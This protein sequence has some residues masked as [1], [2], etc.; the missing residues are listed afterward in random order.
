MNILEAED[1][2]K[3]LP[4]Q[5]L[6]Q[7]AQNPPPQIP[8]YLAVSEVQ[9]R[10]DMRQ[11]F[12]S[13]QAAQ[14]Q[15]TV[16]DQILQGGI[17]SAGGPPPGEA[18]PGGP[19][20]MAPPGGA[21]PMGGGQP[22][23][24]AAAGGMMPYSMG[25]GGSV[26]AGQPDP[27]V[28]KQFM[29]RN[30]GTRQGLASNIGLI[31][32]AM[33]G[34]PVGAGIGGNLGTYIGQKISPAPPPLTDMA[35][36][37]ILGGGMRAPERTNEG[38]PPEPPPF[39]DETEGM[40]VGGLVIPELGSSFESSPQS[41]YNSQ[42][43]SP[44]PGLSRDAVLRK[45]KALMA[46]GRQM[47]ALVLLRQAGVNPS[48]LGMATGGMTPGGIVYMQ[49]GRTVPSE[50]DIRRILEKSPYQRTAE[51]NELLRA[52]GI[53]LSRRTIPREGL[54]LPGTEFIK[55][56]VDP[57]GLTGFTGQIYTPPA[58]PPAA[59]AAAPAAAPGPVDFMAAQ[60]SQPPMNFNMPPPAAIA[61]PQAA[62]Q[63]APPAAAN[64]SPGGIGDLA[65]RQP[66]AG[67][68]SVTG[69]ASELFKPQQISEQEQ[70]LINLINQQREQGVPAPLNLEP[71]RQAALE[72]Q[73][74]AR[75]EARRTAIAGT[76]M[77]LGTGLV[78]GDPAAG[79]R[80]ATQTAME[81]LREGRREAAAEGR[82]AEQLQLQAAQQARQA[83][84]EKMQFDRESLG[85]VANIYKDLN[86]SNKESR[87]RALQ[88]FA[89]Y[90]ASLQSN[91]SRLQEQGALD[92][93]SI[94]SAITAAEDRIEDALE[95]QVG[96]TA[97][98]KDKI[99]NTMR[100][101]AIR[102]IGSLFP[103]LDVEGMI[104]G[105]RGGNQP[106]GPREKPLSAFGR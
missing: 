42:A 97:E 12:Q 18:P 53:E 34:G 22:P 55:R 75:D 59:P 28:F 99:R 36:Q 54:T 45:A 92:R 104:G 43:S 32:G 57:A 56:F 88:I 37:R 26:P 76:L 82:S 101:R 27:Q 33:L 51:E 35:M 24:M 20:P 41:S 91:I 5:V 61:P 77:G 79:L 95:T 72:R 16:K 81:T 2:V 62:P 49:T 15:P 10:Q 86:K 73:K 102:Q 58:A 14:Q 66:R 11:R 4:D 70:A 65:P 48:E 90:D 63:A 31:A 9:R 98:D 84:I 21:P 96:M 52:S 68:M 23:V 93:R 105:G 85:T 7:Y 69:M 46:Q 67:G 13:Q 29:K 74:E 39:V 106:S 60:R 8:Q 94:L 71:Y 103:N 44:P 87:E 80:Q 1:M 25:N 64:V 78:A 30:F 3:G 89:T 100:E 17:A 38:A 19:P 47:D 6:F 83:Q 50:E 40:A